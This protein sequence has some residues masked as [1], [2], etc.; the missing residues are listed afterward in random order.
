MA[1]NVIDKVNSRLTFLHR[2]N[3]FLKSTLR[4]LLSNALMQPLF[5]YG[6]RA[7]FPNPSKKLRVRLKATQN[8]CMRFFLPEDK[9]SRIFAK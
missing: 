4:R 7:W 1:L 3:R 9:I 8:I 5:D 6:C 2:L